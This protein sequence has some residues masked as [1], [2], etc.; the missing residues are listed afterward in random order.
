MTAKR[1]IGVMS[2]GQTRW[3]KQVFSSLLQGIFLESSSFRTFHQHLDEEDDAVLC[4]LGGRKL[5]LMTSEVN[6]SGELERLAGSND[7]EMGFTDAAKYLRNLGSQQKKLVRYGVLEKGKSSYLPYAW[8]HAVLTLCDEERVCCMYYAEM[9][10]RLSLVA[11]AWKRCQQ[12][13]RV[14][15]R[16]GPDDSESHDSE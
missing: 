11:S 15:K 12:H 8:C 10:T 13:C 1:V 2:G 3:P 16:R 4:L 9:Q 14:N 5:W 6:L 7:S